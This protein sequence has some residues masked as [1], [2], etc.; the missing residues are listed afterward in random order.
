MLLRVAIFAAAVLL[1]ACGQSI[2]QQCAAVHDP[3]SN[4]FRSC[5]KDSH[6]SARSSIPQAGKGGHL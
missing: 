4:D 1:S 3:G 2:N 5:V 6:K